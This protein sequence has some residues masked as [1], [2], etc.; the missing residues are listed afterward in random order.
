MQKVIV[1]GY[2]VIHADPDLRREM[3][4]RPEDARRALLD[5]IRD[6]LADRQLRVTVVFDG[7]GGLAEGEVVVPGRLQTLY[8]AAG[9]SADALILR[10]IGRGPDARRYI[11]V[12]SD[13]ADVGRAARAVGARVMASEAFLARIAGPAGAPEPGRDAREKPE[14]DA[15]DTAFW[16]E[17]F[18]ERGEAPGE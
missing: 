13:M 14:P 17:R 2:N 1:D 8:S 10:T 5:R 15:A 16:L 7:A 9:D 18:E 11:V 3:A 4:V 6:Y 12:S